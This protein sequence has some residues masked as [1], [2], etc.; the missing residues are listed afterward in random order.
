MGRL[1]FTPTERAALDQQRRN[2][3][4]S[5]P[6]NAVGITIN[7]LVKRS[8]GKNTVWINGVAHEERAPEGA[9][10]ERR[11]APGQVS[12]RVTESGQSVT[13][14]AGQ[15]FYPDSGE[16]HEGYKTPTT[17]AAGSAPRKAQ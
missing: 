15:T 1:F 7:G 16:V 11:I 17:P 12:G 9:L 14:K 5:L 6:Q 13:L 8:D 10:K 2:D 4:V 3:G